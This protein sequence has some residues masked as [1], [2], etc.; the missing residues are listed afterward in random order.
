MPV[1]GDAS[2]AGQSAD[3]VPV[4]FAAKFAGLDIDDVPIKIPLELGFVG[5]MAFTL[6]TSVGRSDCGVD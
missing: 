1:A 6:F 4:T 3:A 5:N 2:G